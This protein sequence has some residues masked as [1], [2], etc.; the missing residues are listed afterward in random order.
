MTLQDMNIAR[1]IKIKNSDEVIHC[2]LHYFS[3]AFE[4][5]YGM[6]A[7][8]RLVNDEGVVYSRFHGST[9]DSQVCHILQTKRKIGVSGLTDKRSVEA[10][11]FTYS[12]SDMIGSKEKDDHTSDVMLAS[13][14]V[15]PVVLSIL[16]LAMQ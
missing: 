13:L 10:P 2:S 4:I 14:H 15:S 9:Y 16:K 8:I 11:P 7:Y 6:S 12:E 1:C 5:G 3:D